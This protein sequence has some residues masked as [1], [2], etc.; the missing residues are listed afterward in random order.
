[1]RF[2]YINKDSQRSELYEKKVNDRLKQ[3][4]GV[5]VSTNYEELQGNELDEILK[6]VEK[7]EIQLDQLQL[8]V[9]ELSSTLSQI[10]LKMLKEKLKTKAE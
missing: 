6:K 4:L 2:K 7:V 9:N 10:C 1:M 8:K 3:D 5:K